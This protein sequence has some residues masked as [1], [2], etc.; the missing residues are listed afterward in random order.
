MWVL[1]EVLQLLVGSL[2]FH[3]IHLSNYRID[4]VMAQTSLTLGQQT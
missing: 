2:L 1:V 4:Y 3:Q